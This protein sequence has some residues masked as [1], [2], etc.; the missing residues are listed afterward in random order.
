LTMR[1]ARGCKSQ[2]E[3]CDDLLVFGYSC[4]LFRDDEKAA[5]IDAGGHLIPWMG[6]HDLMIDRYVYVVGIHRR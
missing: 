5:N 1:A 4:K 6:R 2:E 3:T